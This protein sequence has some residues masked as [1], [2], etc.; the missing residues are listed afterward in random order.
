[1][2]HQIEPDAVTNRFDPVDFASEFPGRLHCEKTRTARTRAIELPGEWVI[3]IGISP[4]ESRKFKDV[5]VGLEEAREI[6]D[7]LENGKAVFRNLGESEKSRLAEELEATV[8]FAEEAVR[9]PTA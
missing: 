1:M 8:E 9:E 6:L 5:Y 4:Q 2:P 3:E 7:R